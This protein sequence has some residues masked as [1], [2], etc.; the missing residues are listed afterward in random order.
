MIKGTSRIARTGATLVSMGMVATGATV[1][2]SPAEAAP[3]KVAT[4]FA[5]SASSWGSRV[6]NDIAEFAPARLGYSNIACTR[7]AGRKSVAGG[8]TDALPEDARKLIRLQAMSSASETYRTAAGVTGSRGVTTIGDIR[9]GPSEGPFVK[10][11]GLRSVADSFHTPGKGFG[12]ATDFTFEGIGI[13]VGDALPEEISEPLQDLLD[14]ISEN[15]REPANT[16]VSAVTGVLK[17]AGPGG[18]AIPGLG[19]IAL[20]HERSKAR[21]GFA[22]SSTYALKLHL[23]AIQTKV[24][25]GRAW[26]RV[27]RNRP[28]QVFH[29]AAILGRVNLAETGQGGPLTLLGRILMQG[30][31]CEGTGGKFKAERVGESNILGGLV[32]VTGAKSESMGKHRKNGSAVTV[33]RSTIGS[34]QLLGPVPVE[35]RGLVSQARVVQ[36]PRGRIKR[37]VPTVRIAQVLV[38]GKEITLHPSGVTEFDGGFIQTTGSGKNV[39]RLKRGIAVTG[40]RVGLSDAGPLGRI[41]ELGLATARIRRN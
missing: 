39:K 17:Q 37:R 18:I 36:G 11:E 29:G 20:G 27:A 26:S 13:D 2:A 1:L 9:L 31:R 6:V 28:D 34:V 8:M 24:D 35:V 25:L 23:D 15:T 12:T 33:L 21:A 10:I 7:M 22:E 38:D 3:R 19:K 4:D 41:V 30:V 16:L 5:F 32:K 14:A 40:I